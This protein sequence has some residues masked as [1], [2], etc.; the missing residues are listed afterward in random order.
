MLESFSH[1]RCLGPIIFLVLMALPA[2]AFAA[3]AAKG[4]IIAKRWCATCHQV[5]PD[6][7]PVNSDVPSFVSISRQKKLTSKV[8]TDFLSTPHPKM[9]DMHL[10]RSEIADVV[11]YIE[12]L[13]R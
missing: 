1:A 9:P 6:Q 3:D 5:S 13:G 10:S 2:S 12:S 11:A 4:E 7:K 8:L